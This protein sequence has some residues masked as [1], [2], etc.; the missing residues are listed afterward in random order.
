MPRVP[1]Y[2]NFQ[3]APNGLPQVALRAPDQPDVAGPQ[4]QALAAGMANLSGVAGRMAL[5]MQ[6]EANTLRVDDALNRAREAA[7]R[8]THDKD[9]GFTN[10]RGIQALERPS[11]KPLADEYADNLREELSRIGD[12]LGNDFQK[13]AF[14]RASN[15]LLTQF[16]GQATKH[17]S[18]QFRDYALSVRDGTIASRTREI[19]LNYNNPEVIDQ[20]LIS[21]QAA[22]RDQAKLLGKSQVWA[23]AQAMR[24]TSNAHKV[25][26]SAAIENNDI[27]F[28]DA[29]LKKYAKDMEADDILRAR[30]L[31]TKEL[32]AQVAL[33]TATQVMR[34]LTPRIVT[35]DVDRAFNIALKTES[36]GRQFGADGKPLTSPKGAI[37]IAQ[38]MPATAPEAAKLAGLPWDEQRY[39]NDPKYNEALGRVYFQ[40]QLQEFEGNLAYAYAAYNAGPG[41]TR[42]A[43]QKAEMSAKLGKNDPS[44]KQ[45]TWLEFLPKETQD[46]VTKNLEGYSKGEGSYQRP[47]LEEVHAEVRARLGTTSPSRLRMA[48]D[49][50]TRQ[51]SDADKAVKQREEEA[52][53]TAMREVI[54][55]GGR[56][57]DLP[58]RVRAAIPPK[59]VDNVMNFAQRIAKGNDVTNMALYQKLA[60]DPQYLRGLTDNQFFRLRSELSE[61]DFKHFANE[62]AASASGAKGNSAQDLNTPAI[63]STLN[64][65]LRTLGMDPTPKDGSADAQRVGAIHKF[66]RDSILNAQMTS[67]KKFTDAEVDKHI[68][69]LF[70]KSQQFRT[71]FLGMGTGTTA[72]RLLTMKAGDIPGDILDRLRKDFK[73]AGIPDPTDGDLLGAYWQLKFAKR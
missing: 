68:D 7:M 32:D 15:D 44:V 13:T 18:D 22:A 50:A 69:A 11:G 36:G 52:V 38:V 58:V 35:T 34:D 26:L 12:G 14:S 66:V 30:G 46:Y 45:F 3:A 72:Q 6:Q 48:L 31:I 59:E 9:V 53:A 19:G 73:A 28:A 8:L 41:A 62:R 54:G 21:I 67:G 55:N 1:T 17:E 43:I 25:A 37:G 29:Y 16:R 5:D 57:S 61:S 71:S 2:D 65:R 51:F 70:A 4:T 63:N 47:T 60:N 42:K 40:K 20:A 27:S 33:G 56:F 24:V 23:D 39:R 64:D 49:E 10:Q